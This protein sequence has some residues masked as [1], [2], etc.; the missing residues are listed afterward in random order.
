VEAV[1][2]AQEV[3][4]DRPAATSPPEPDDPEAVATATRRGD[5][6]RGAKGEVPISDED[7]ALLQRRD[8]MVEAVQAQLLR[9]LKRAMQDEQNDLLD[10]LRGLRQRPTIATLLPSPDEQA[11]RYRTAA[12]PFLGEAAL[13]GGR[14]LSGEAETGGPSP[15][16]DVGGVAGALGV[17]VATPLR[18]RLERALARSDDDT[19]ALVDEVG[20]IYREWKSQRI[21]EVAGDHVTAAFG[22]GAVAAVA[23][24]TPLRWLVDD[25]DGPCPDCDDNALARP[26]PAGEEFPT[27]QRHP[28]AHRGCRCIVVRDDTPGS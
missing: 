19:R 21:D 18:E 22:L 14:F 5:P 28:P 10:R 6:R 3:L 20:A 25:N 15:V 26:T 27:G 8:A 12:T 9:K 17:A 1:A 7:E 24:G 13:A 23:P 11:E 4:A 2:H 16:A